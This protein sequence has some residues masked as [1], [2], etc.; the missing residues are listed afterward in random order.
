MGW[1]TTAWQNSDWSIAVIV[2][3]APD[4]WNALNERKLILGA[5]AEH[6]PIKSADV[7]A[8]TAGAPASTSGTFSWAYLQAWIA[9]N[10]T[11]FVQSHATTGAALASD[12]YEGKTA[13]TMWTATNL[14]KSI[15][16]N[17]AST[18]FRRATTLP[19]NW[20]DFTDPAYSY[21]IMQPGD[22]I[23]PW[24]FLDLQRAFNRL[25]WTKATF[26]WDLTGADGKYGRNL[27]NTSYADAMAGLAAA[28]PVTD[29]TGDSVPC[30]VY[31]GE[32]GW[33]AGWYDALARTI[34]ATGSMSLYAGITRDIDWMTKCVPYNAGTWDDNGHDVAN[35]TWKTWH[36]DAG[37]TDATPTS[38][39]LGDKLTLPDAAAPGAGS[40]EWRGWLVSEYAALV[41]WNV[42][43]GLVYT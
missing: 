20:M 11:S 21:G 5:A 23:G 25:I 7:H 30:G 36:T 1:N 3:N 6:V 32:N 22:I 14:Y 24:V 31:Y 38:A 29:Y 13:I 35:G 34:E 16:A 15:Y 17:E 9:S 19:A 12:F 4:F 41:R 18:G 37:D 26:T 2:T 43:S 27:V 39:M 42:A 40:Y 10:C 28:W 8:A 33:S